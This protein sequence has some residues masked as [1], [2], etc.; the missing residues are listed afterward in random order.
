M[1]AHIYSNNL[2][3]NTETKQKYN[4]EPPPEKRGNDKKKHYPYAISI[5]KLNHSKCEPIPSS[6]ILIIN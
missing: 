3:E 5:L 1:H 4:K 2:C 6:K